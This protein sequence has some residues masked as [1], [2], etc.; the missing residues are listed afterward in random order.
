MKAGDRVRTVQP[1]ETTCSQIVTGREFVVLQVTRPGRISIGD[2]SG[3]MV[4]CD[5]LEDRFEVICDAG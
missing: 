3:R 1:V 4:V 2:K 5:C